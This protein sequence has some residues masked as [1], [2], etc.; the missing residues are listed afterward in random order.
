MKI[1]HNLTNRQ[2]QGIAEIFSNLGLLFF[3]SIIV[4]IFSDVEKL[5]LVL[6]VVGFLLTLF[7][8]FVSIKLFRKVKDN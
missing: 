5:N 1:Y 4:P 6:T 7:C 8:W 2:V 3:G